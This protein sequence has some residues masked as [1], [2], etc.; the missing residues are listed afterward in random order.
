MRY[1]FR[2]MG[3]WPH[4]SLGVSAHVWPPKHAHVSLHLPLGVLIIGYRGED[5]Q[6]FLG[7]TAVGQDWCDDYTPGPDGEH[8]ARCRYPE[9]GHE[10]SRPADLAY[11]R[12]KL[13]CAFCNRVRAVPG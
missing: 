13:G 4:V 6:P 8:C 9:V 7:G 1:G 10:D 3:T 5:T 2:W 11:Q 12:H